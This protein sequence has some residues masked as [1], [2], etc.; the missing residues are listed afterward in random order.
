[1]HCIVLIVSTLLDTSQRN[2]DK[3]ELSQL[4]PGEAQ[5]SSA[6]MMLRE[7]M[8]GWQHPNSEHRLTY[9]LAED[10]KGK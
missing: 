4:V 9:G 7:I 8:L 5:S 10:Q 6:R 2:S 1:M 3:I